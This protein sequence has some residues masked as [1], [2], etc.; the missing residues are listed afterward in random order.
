MEV[1]GKIT[2]TEKIQSITLFVSR[3]KFTLIG[4]IIIQIGIF[5]DARLAP[6]S[7]RWRVAG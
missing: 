1:I 5:L 6:A 7:R 3:K 4:L 2:L